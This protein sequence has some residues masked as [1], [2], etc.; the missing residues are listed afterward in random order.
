MIHQFTLWSAYSFKSFICHRS[1]Q[2]FDSV[3]HC[4][5]NPID[6]P[7]KPHPFECHQPPD[8][9]WD[10]HVPAVQRQPLRLFIHMFTYYHKYPTGLRGITVG[11][12]YRGTEMSRGH[13]DWGDLCWL[14]LMG[15]TGQTRKQSTYK[16]APSWAGDIMCHS[17]RGCGACWESH[18][19]K[20]RICFYASWGA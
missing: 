17:E 15:D 18:S 16:W 2:S 10:L 5:P 14:A 11:L 4:R 6:F 20:A 12:I 19:I 9:H 8:K 7:L 13:S 3:F 1:K